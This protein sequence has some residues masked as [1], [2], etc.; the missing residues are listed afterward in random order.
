MTTDKAPV[1]SVSFG[2]AE[3]GDA[4]RGRVEH[5]SFRRTSSLNLSETVYLEN[6]Q[7]DECQSSGKH[8]HADV[9][10][11]RNIIEVDNI[12]PSANAGGLW[13]SQNS[14]AIERR[15]GFSPKLC[16]QPER[17][18]TGSN[19]AILMPMVLSWTYLDRSPEHEGSLCQS[20]LCMAS[21]AQKQ[22]APGKGFE[23]LC[24]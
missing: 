2:T 23:P 17:V 18:S 16:R 21:Q 22:M 24:P 8:F 6:S 3:G 9:N 7:T 15:R 13:P 4:D 5:R 19:I 1:D 12:Q 11:R 10:V 14:C 20:H